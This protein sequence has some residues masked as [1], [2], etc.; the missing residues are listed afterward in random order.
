[1]RFLI[2]FLICFPV[3]FA[4]SQK[5][6][7]DVVADMPAKLKESSGLEITGTNQFWSHNDSGGKNQ[8]YCF[9]GNGKITKTVTI[10][11]VSNHDW[12]DLAQDKNGNF[13][14]ADIGNNLNSRKFSKIFIIP[15][16]ATLKS[17]QTKAKIIQFKYAD[18]KAYPPPSNQLHFDAEALIAHNN[19]LYIFTKNRT[20]P[21]DG[22][23]K[24]YRVPAIEGTHTAQLVDSLFLGKGGSMYKWWITAAD[25]SPDGKKVVLLGSDK[26]WVL[27]GFKGDNFLSGKSKQYELSNFSQ[28]EG[29]AFADNNTV[30]FCDE[31]TYLIMGGNFYK[32]KL[33]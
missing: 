25:I 21:Y 2:S 16:P 29:I 10:S 5:L 22:Y 15:N 3:A 1:M 13:Y 11:N 14:I 32:A 19:N 26:L 9:D 23:V 27:S 31:V 12:E 30:Y 18:Q 33:P 7:V 24:L 6:D 8:I 20:S 28:K 17:D 4:Q